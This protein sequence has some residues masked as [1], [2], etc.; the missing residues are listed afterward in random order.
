[1][2]VEDYKKIERI[3]FKEI[4]RLTRKRKTGFDYKLIKVDLLLQALKTCESCVNP[5]SLSWYKLNNEPDW[6]E[7]ELMEED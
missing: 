5:E 6:E 4:H 2:K 3:I 7:D 1:M